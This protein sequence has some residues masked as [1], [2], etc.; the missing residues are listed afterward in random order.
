MSDLLMLVRHRLAQGGGSYGSPVVLESVTS[1][2]WTERWQDYGEAQVSL[3][4]GA[5]VQVGDILTMA[6]RDMAVEVVAMTSTERGAELRCRDALSVLDRRIVYPTVANNG[7]VSTFVT[8]LISP[9]LGPT[10]RGIWPLRMG[11]ISA[12]T[13]SASIQRSYVHIGEVLL[14]LA[15]TYGFDMVCRLTDGHLVLGARTNTATRTWTPWQGLAGYTEDIDVSDALTVAYVGA[16]EDAHGNRVVKAIGPSNISNLK[17]REEF[18]DRRDLAVKGMDL[19]ALESSFGGIT[20]YG[21]ATVYVRTEGRG[22]TT[23]VVDLS[24]EAK[25]RVDDL[26]A[27][28][29]IE[30]MRQATNNDPVVAQMIETASPSDTYYSGS[31]NS[32]SGGW[33]MHFGST[34]IVLPESILGYAM[35]D[36]SDPSITDVLRDIGQEA[37]ADHQPETA[38]E[39]RTEGLAPYTD[40]NLGDTVTI[41]KEDGSTRAM[42]VVEVVET[43]DSQG[44]RAT[45]GLA[46]L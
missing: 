7:L 40:Y 8:R 45:P 23:T 41:V 30:S 13:G 20:N 39:A 46:S 4:P 16:Q 2:V 11:D 17:R 35:F 28:A 18:V 27:T 3:G 21:T 32:S 29:T 22:A 31:Y 5:D 6:G 25:V 15:K 1:A 12:I 34:D 26:E 14:E 33:V 44:Y 42:R 37:L 38:F 24:L 10:T 43:W 19:S 36:L 9:I